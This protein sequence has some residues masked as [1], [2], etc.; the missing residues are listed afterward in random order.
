[1][2]WLVRGPPDDAGLPIERNK[3]RSITGCRRLS[4]VAAAASFIL[5]AYCFCRRSLYRFAI[6]CSSLI[7]SDD[8]IQSSI[9]RLRRPL[10]LTVDIHLDLLYYLQIIRHFHISHERKDRHQRGIRLFYGSH[11]ITSTTASGVGRN[12]IRRRPNTDDY[13]TIIIQQ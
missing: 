4:S 10:T 13:S 6:V 9:R 3:Q 12:Q 2:P 7:T 11:V 8:R 5:P 1:M